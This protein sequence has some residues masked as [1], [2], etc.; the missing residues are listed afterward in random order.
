M[1]AIAGNNA[2]SDT[3]TLHFL[4]EIGERG[5]AESSATASGLEKQVQQMKIN[6]ELSMTPPPVPI[7]FH[8]TVV[9]VSAMKCF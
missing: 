1:R 5:R 7:E 4:L 6:S 9:K 2:K 8:N 3:K